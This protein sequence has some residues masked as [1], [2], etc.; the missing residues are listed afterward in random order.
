MRVHD[1]RHTAASIAISSGANVKAVQRMVGHRDATMTLKR[2]AHLFDTD[3]DRV[4]E[5]ISAKAS[6][7][8]I[9]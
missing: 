5:D 1:L 4:A 3:L 6:S 8:G 7:A 9:D 2:Y